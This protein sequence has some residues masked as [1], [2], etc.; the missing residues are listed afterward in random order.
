M[1]PAKYRSKQD[2]IRFWKKRCPMFIAE[3][4]YLQTNSKVMLYPEYALKIHFA[5]YMF[6]NLSYG[7]MVGDGD[8]VNWIIRYIELTSKADY[9]DKE[10][11][12]EIVDELLEFG[13][14]KVDFN[15]AI[16]DLLEESDK[17]LS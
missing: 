11:I 14:E 13:C 7:E 1:R 16:S 3:H 10:L 4:N 9:P 17:F 6:I 5:Y 15:G 8:T 2:F 12:E